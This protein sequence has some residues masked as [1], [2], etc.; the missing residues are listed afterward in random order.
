[1]DDSEHSDTLIT[2]ELPANRAATAA[3][4]TLWNG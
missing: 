4:A 1:L 2:A 3:D